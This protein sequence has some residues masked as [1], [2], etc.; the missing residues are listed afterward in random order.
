MKQNI[1]FYY[2]EEGEYAP[3]ENLPFVQRKNIAAV[4]K[5]QDKY[6]FLSWNKVDYQNSL[7]T[8]GIDDDEDIEVAVCREL[9]EETGYCDILSIEEIDCVN[10]SR[11]YVEHKNQ[12]REAIYYPYLVTLNSLKQDDIDLMES[13]EHSHIWVPETDLEQVNLFDNHRKML[14][15]A[16]R[17]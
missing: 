16:L 12:N 1:A 7:V 2:T 4:V 11:F 8:G 14:N 17:R 6:L 13:E 3:K 10:V 15:K 9:N 5:F